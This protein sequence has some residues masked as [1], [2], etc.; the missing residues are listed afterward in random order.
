MSVMLD[1][2][3]QI[4]MWVL[5]S[6]R[7]QL[8]LHEKGLKTPGL[9][10]WLK[11][12]LGITTRNARKARQELNDL[13]GELGGPEDPDTNFNVLIEAAFFPGKYLDDG[14]YPTMEEV[15][16]QYRA[17]FAGRADQIVIMRTLDEPRDP[18]G[19]VMEF[20]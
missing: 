12:N 1:R 16:S 14:I 19:N 7:S 11:D 18:N 13:I 6:R 5:L 2:P 17:A 20:C 4:H 10:K 15:E 9:F 8:Q 3:E